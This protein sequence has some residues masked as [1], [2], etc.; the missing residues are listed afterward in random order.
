MAEVLGADRPCFLA[1]ELTKMHE[2]HLEGTLRELAR[3]FAPRAQ[4]KGEVTLVVGGPAGGAGAAA[5]VAE[6]AAAV[7]RVREKD[8][9]SKMEA[10]KRVARRMH[11]PKSAVY[12]AVLEEE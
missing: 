7:A 4:V 6:M 10:I 5:S 2:E 12:D 1:R 9:V 11:M 8:G 3:R